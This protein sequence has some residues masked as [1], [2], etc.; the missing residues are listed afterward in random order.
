MVAVLAVFISCS[1]L[2][3]DRL[4][5]QMGERQVRDNLLRGVRAY[6]LFAQLRSDI[7][8]SQAR[9]IAQTPLLKAVMNIPEVDP[10]TVYY[11]ARD[12]YEAIGTDL[13]LLVDTQG[14]LL[15][16]ANR[17]DYN[18]DDMSG[19]TGIA[20]GL[21]GGEYGGIWPYRDGL[22]QIA[23]TPIVIG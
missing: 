1:V 18:G 19:M 12:L 16:D 5:L 15:A 23:L 7:V 14:R 17:A 20:E 3:V 8:A 22:Y 13:M 10:E 6:G 21:R 9:S 2:V 11:T 4:A